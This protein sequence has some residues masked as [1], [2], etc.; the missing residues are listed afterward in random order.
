MAMKCNICGAINEDN[1]NYC[2]SCLQ[3]LKG[4]GQFSFND[5]S[6]VNNQEGLSE[7][8]RIPLNGKSELYE[9]NNTKDYKE[10][11][12]LLLLFLYLIEFVLTSILIELITTILFSGLFKENSL[13]DIGLNYVVI[14]LIP[15]VALSMLL[16]KK[17]PRDP[18]IFSNTI[19]VLSTLFYTTLIDMRLYLSDIDAIY[20]SE[21]IK[22]CLLALSVSCF[23]ANMANYMIKKRKGD[24]HTNKRMCITNSIV[25][26]LFI[27]L[28]LIGIYTKENGMMITGYYARW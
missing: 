19:L 22:G 21:Y 1:V 9:N 14:L 12:T 3:P 11:S 17:I 28:F 8:M 10:K 6:S 24:H 23:T 27:L 20:V 7:Q 25:I 18:N 26:A 4:M 15:F 16:K 5:F 13:L 2:Y